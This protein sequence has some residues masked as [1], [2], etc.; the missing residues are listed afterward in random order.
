[1]DT[2]GEGSGPPPVQTTEERMEQMEAQMIAMREENMQLLEE[3]AQ[4][5]A[6]DK[7]KGLERGR[8]PGPPL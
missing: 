4:A 7:G 5:R 2:G 8:P 3:L 1:M 6:G